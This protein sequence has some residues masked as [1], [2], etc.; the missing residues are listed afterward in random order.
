MSV[1]VS[2]LTVGD[3]RDKKGFTFAP[4]IGDWQTGITIPGNGTGVVST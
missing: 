4:T 2:R 1:T 3:V